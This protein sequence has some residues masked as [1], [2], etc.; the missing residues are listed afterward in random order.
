MALSTYCRACGKYLKI[1]RGA[2][3]LTSGPQLSGIASVR[4]VSDPLPAPV[5]EEESVEVAEETAPARDTWVKTK[6]NS[7]KARKRKKGKRKRARERAAQEAAREKEFAEE[8]EAQP[9]SVA[10]VFGLTGEDGQEHPPE[11]QKEESTGPNGINLG[12]EAASVEELTEGSMGAMISDLVEQEEKREIAKAAPRARETPKPVLAKKSILDLTKT[13]VHV[14]CFRC[15]HCQWE[16]KH[17]E[18]TQCGRCNTYISLADYNI[19]QPTDRV[20]RTRGNVTVHRR[21]TI[22]GSE[23][24]CRDL[25]AM[26]PIDTKLDCSGEARFK[27]SA[28]I[29]GHLHCITLV[30]DRG[31]NVEFPDGV[32]TQSARI[33]GEL[34]GNVV[35]AGSIEIHRSGKVEGDVS[36]HAVDL[37]DDAALTGVMKIDPDISIELPELKGYDPSIID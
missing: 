33:S 1:E 29:R 37:Q 20:I 14:R 25:V 6:D 30:I 32:H 35:C 36:A 3:I 34:K 11:K 17:A 16:S 26:G 9:A 13:R 21:G 23:L 10:E 24:A 18:S 5:E 28:T 2:A 31:V 8:S 19:R 22:I 4:D 15:N 27:E 7:E 12:K